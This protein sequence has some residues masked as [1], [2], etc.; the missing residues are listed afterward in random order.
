M[1][2]EHLGLRLALYVHWVPYARNTVTQDQDSV[3]YTD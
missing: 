2:A 1:L 3:H